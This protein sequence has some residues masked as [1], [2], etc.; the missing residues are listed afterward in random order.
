M[1]NSRMGLIQTEEQLK[2][3]Y[4]AI[5]EGAAQAG[6]ISPDIVPQGKLLHAMVLTANRA[7]KAE[8][9]ALAAMA[10]RLERPV[11]VDEVK[12]ALKDVGSKRER[13]AGSPAD[14]Q[15]G[16]DEKQCAKRRKSNE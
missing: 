10:S 1:R 12:E 11:V 8:L 15:D 16:D 7:E 4:L 14:Q 3:S 9:M 13:P 5:A 6:Y 2:F